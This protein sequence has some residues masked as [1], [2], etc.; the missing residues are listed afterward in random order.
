MSRKLRILLILIGSLLVVAGLSAW[1]LYGAVYNKN[2]AQN[3]KILIQVNESTEYDDVQKAF[4][5]EVI[6]ESN[7]KFW[8]VAKITG[9]DKKFKPGRYAIKPGMSN[10]AIL[11]MLSLG[12]QEQVKL[13]LR[14]S[15]T[16]EGL[17]S[18][19]S[20][21]LAA[22]STELMQLL[23]SKAYLA[24]HNWK[25]E[26]IPALFI[27]NTYFFYYNTS[28]EQFLERMFKEYE[29]FWNDKRKQKAQAIDLSPVEV[30]ILASIVDKETAKLDEMSTVAGVYLNRLR[31]GWKLEA[32][33]TV[34]FAVG[35]PDIR[36]VTIAMTEYES[37]Y[38]TYFVQGL[39]PG[40]ICIPSIQA[41]DAVLKNKQHDYL[42]FCAKEDFSGYH[43][44]TDNYK[45]HQLNSRRYQLELNKRGIR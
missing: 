22:D 12:Q 21:E 24:Q 6:L 28:A 14:G 30:S 16:L 17:A 41:I 18:H 2:T 43:N 8:T 15:W 36:R 25:P 11:R 10:I 1:W 38:N 26:T 3:R 45:Q 32:D 27:P 9:Y 44:F 13:V 19:V 7:F 5:T 40:P 29:K 39:P 4:K 35:N 31:K 37:P 42:F 33:P 34:I 20:A 23:L